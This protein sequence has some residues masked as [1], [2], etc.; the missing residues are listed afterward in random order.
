M[1]NKI[2]F[3]FRYPSSFVKNDLEILKENYD[4]IPL[5][6]TNNLLKTLFKFLLY[7]RK[8]DLIFVWFA[9]HQGFLSVL[10]AKI[11]KKKS[12]VIV[13]GYDV[14]EVPELNYGAFTK[15]KRRFPAKYCL[16]HADIVLPVSNFTKAETLKRVRPKR[17][18]VVYNG[19]DVEKFKSCGW[20]DDNLVITVGGICWSNLKMKGI[21][22]FVRTAKLV[23][24]ARFVVIG[25][26]M[27]SS[28]DYIK[29]IAPLNVK[30]TGFVSHE[31][32]FKYLQKAK[33]YCQL[34]IR[35]S[36]GM[37]LAEAM[38][39]EC[40]PV[41]TNN[42][43]LPEVVGNT[44]F[45]IPYDDEKA[46]VEAIKQALASPE[47]GKMARERIISLFSLKEREKQL[48]KIIN[49]VIEIKGEKQ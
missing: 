30:F 25:K 43:A 22:N 4:V 29:S 15:L 28:I 3:V 13:G 47:K 38:A 5:H 48:V 10:F 27:N 6:A 36:F 49:E 26:F 40:V 37:A 35:E 20:K 8:V 19:V 14:A 45:Y 42:G 32:I 1:K 23:P 41:V 17:I 31:E 7:T 16:K 21:E 18:E 9:G 34:S 44:G 11:F 33:I 12:I 39:C 46:T 2:L 24:E